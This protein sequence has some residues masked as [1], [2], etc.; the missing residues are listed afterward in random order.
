VKW[1]KSSEQLPPRD[2]EF[3]ALHTKYDNV[4]IILMCYWNDEA[5][6]Y[7][8]PEAGL[9]INISCC[10]GCKIQNR[11][12]DEEFFNVLTYWR[13]IPELPLDVKN[14]YEGRREMD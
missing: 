11:P 1:I 9:Y 14:K 3:L 8:D 10:T 6:R 5:T 4:Y 7:Q 2:R 12:S 13:D